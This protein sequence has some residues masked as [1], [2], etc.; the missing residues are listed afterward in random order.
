VL[1][2][3]GMMIVKFIQKKKDF[4]ACVKVLYRNDIFL[5]D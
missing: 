1:L 3:D 4:N 2:I 5:L